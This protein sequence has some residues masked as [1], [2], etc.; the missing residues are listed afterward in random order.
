MS[1]VARD[2][3]NSKRQREEKAL[4]HSPPGTAPEGSAREAAGKW[5]RRNQSRADVEKWMLWEEC[6]HR[7]PYYGRLNLI[8]TVYSGPA[9]STWS[10]SGRGIPFARQQFPEQDPLPQGCERSG[11]A[12][13]PRTSSSETI[14]RKSG[15]ALANRLCRYEG[16][17]RAESGMSPGKIRK[18]PGA[19]AIPED[20]A[21]RQL[22]D[23]GYAAREAVAY[24]KKL[25]PDLGTGSARE[26]SSPYRGGSRGISADCGR[27]NYILADDGDKT[28]AD[29]R[30]HAIDALTVA[31]CHPGMTQKLSRHW[32]EEDDPRAAQPHLPSALGSD[33]KRRRK[34]RCSHCRVP[35]RPQKGLRTAPQGDGVRRYG[36][37]CR[38]AG[39]GTTYRYFVRRKAVEELKNSASER[40]NGSRIIDIVDDGVREIVR[41]LGRESRWR[42]Q[43]L[44]SRTAYPKTG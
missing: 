33:S 43:A 31:C 28:R 20:F 4:R 17:P 26:C 13:G 9:N 44:R 11:R 40:F 29:H 18:I 38:G 19:A 27:L 15:H 12:T 34:G 2:V 25:W 30:H 8:S 22:N 39:R 23:T 16:P 3:G 42:P 37:G 14:P 1:R 10:T 36:R 35:S 41:R 21:T 6:G 7:C 24:L 32:Q 5:N